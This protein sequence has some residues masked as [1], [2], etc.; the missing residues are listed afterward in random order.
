MENNKKMK[1]FSPGCMENNRQMPMELYSPC[2]ILGEN[3]DNGNSQ[4]NENKKTS[5]ASQ[6]QTQIQLQQISEGGIQLHCHL[7]VIFHTP[8]GKQLHFFVIFHTYRGIQ[9]HMF[10]IIYAPRGIQLHWDLFVI[11]YTPR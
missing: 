6:A 5:K 8:R 2:R 4:R 7:S 3:H 11:F 10:L 9:L 1:L